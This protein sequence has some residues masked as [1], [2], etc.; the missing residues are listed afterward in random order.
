MLAEDVELHGDGGGRA[1]ALARPL[2]GRRRVAG[3]LSAWLALARS[4][5]GVEGE[6]VE[7]N[8]EPGVLVRDADG[9]VLAVWAIG[10][11]GDRVQS[12]RSIVNPDKLGHLGRVGTIGA[13]LERARRATARRGE[14]G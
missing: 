11:A 6:L 10:I 2:H 14:R 3:A 13:V 5:G 9:A 7:V 12:I 4:A 1:P 8:G